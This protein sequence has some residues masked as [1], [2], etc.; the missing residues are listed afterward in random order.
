LATASRNPSNWPRRTSSTLARSAERPL[1]VKE[2]RHAKASPDFLSCL[3]GEQRA[4]LQFDAGDGH[5]GS[6]QPRRCGVN[7]AGG[8]V[9]QLNGLAHT[10]HCGFNHRAD[11]RQVS[12]GSGCGQRHGPVEQMHAFDAHR[13]HNGLDPRYPCPRRSWEHT[14]QPVRSS[15]LSPWL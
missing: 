10:A 7:P 9:D 14:R 6:H 8:Q 11:R 2:Y 12:P 5:K 1:P 3:A 13:G 15:S 4:L